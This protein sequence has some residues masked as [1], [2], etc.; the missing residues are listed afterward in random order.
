MKRTLIVMFAVLGLYLALTFSFSS[1]RENRYLDS[2]GRKESGLDYVKLEDGYTAYRIIG[3]DTGQVVIMIHGGTIP[4]CIWTD[5]SRI[6]AESGYRVLLYDQYGRGNSDR[7]NKE[8]NRDLFTRQLKG[9]INK[10]KLDEPF[11]IIGP[12]FGGAIAVSFA[13]KYPERVRSMILI[14]PALNIPGSD[15]PLNMPMRVVRVPLIGRVF[16]ET[17]M[18]NQIIERGRQN[19]PGGI[20]SPC[21]SMF[22]KQFTFK[23][24]HRGLYCKFRSDAYGDYLKQAK[25]ADRNVDHILLL[26]GKEDPEITESM[27]DEIKREMPE[28]EYVELEDSGHSPAMDNADLFNSILLSYLQKVD[29][30]KNCDGKK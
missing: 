9:L 30:G 8:Y 27:F 18:M 6:F 15:S 22:M 2:E 12:S 13:S 1:R 4:M 26:R 29:S 14:S 16:F 25:K 19:V 3:P 23:G 7:V 28:S 10:L 20:G 5:Q 24:T 11:D 17:I 21:D